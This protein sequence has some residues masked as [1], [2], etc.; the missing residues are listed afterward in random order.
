MTSLLKVP[1]KERLSGEEQSF[2]PATSLVHH[3]CDLFHP[4][5]GFMDKPAHVYY[6]RQEDVPRKRGGHLEISEGAWPPPRRQRNDLRM[7]ERL[8][9]SKATL[10]QIDREGSTQLASLALGHHWKA[11][12]MLQNLNSAHEKIGSDESIT[13][14][15]FVGVASPSAPTRRAFLAYLA[16]SALFSLAACPP[17]NQ[18]KRRSAQPGHLGPRR[19]LAYA[20]STLEKR[21]GEKFSQAEGT[22]VSALYDRIIQNHHLRITRAARR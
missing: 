10:D 3:R 19:R 17:N 6:D 7:I 22:E 9:S 11:R 2:L 18:K 20:L 16:G 12:D 8:E 21:Y 4:L 1:W 5:V 13:H 14:R 15:H